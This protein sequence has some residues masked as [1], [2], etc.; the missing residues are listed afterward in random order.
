MKGAF[1]L[2]EST[3]INHNGIFKVDSPWT[4]VVFATASPTT[5]NHFLFL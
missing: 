2:L 4:P 5:T 3:K 1:W